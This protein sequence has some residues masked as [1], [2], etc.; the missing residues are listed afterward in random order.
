MSADDDEMKE[1][2]A[3]FREESVER[4]Q[5]C[6]RALEELRT[7]DA[8]KAVEWLNEVDRELHTIKGSSRYLGFTKLGHL[9]HVERAG[10]RVA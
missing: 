10:S 2:L 4:L 5:N 9:V 6:A 8:A 1:F 3:I 7:A